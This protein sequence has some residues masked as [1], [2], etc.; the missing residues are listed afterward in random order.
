MIPNRDERGFIVGQS[1]TGKSVLAKQLMYG[2][3]VSRRIGIIDPKRTFN[4][5]GIKVFDSARA[6]VRAKP[7]AFIY[8]PK[9]EELDNLSEHSRVYQYAYD[10][11]DYFVYTDDI[12]GIVDKNKYPRY[13]QICY[14]MGRERNV[15]MLS[16]TQ[17][18]AWVP[19][20]LRTESTR[21]YAFR[22]VEGKDIRTMREIIPNYNPM[23]FTN[24]HQ[25]AY[26]DMKQMLD[27]QLV[28]IKL[29]A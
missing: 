18:P 26:Y 25:F 8:R 17:R 28:T 7:S 11:G 12:V 10:K 21:M 1:G 6:I 4:Y 14:Q 23:S 20:F 24:L 9:P 2:M 16:A 29:V 15:S 22:L 27:T 13:L 19:L 3:P 5:P